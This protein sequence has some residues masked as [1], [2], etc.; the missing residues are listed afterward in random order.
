MT[1]KEVAQIIGTI[2]LDEGT[3]P[4]AYH[5]FPENDPDNPAPPPPFIC[6]SYAYS[7][8][9]IADNV[10]YQHIRELVIEVYTDNKDF[11]IEAAV[12]AK[13]TANE[14]VFS[15]SEEYIGSEHLYMVTYSAQIVITEENNG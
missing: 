2:P 14:I 13:L 7:N 8:D 9:M 3:I 1:Y 12:E 5:H 15:K 11:D 10:N 6:Y 4:F